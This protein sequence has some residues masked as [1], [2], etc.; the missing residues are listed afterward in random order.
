MTLANRQALPHLAPSL[1]IRRRCL[2]LLTGVLHKTVVLLRKARRISQSAV[3]RAADEVHARRF[4]T[5]AIYRLFTQLLS[6]AY[7]CLIGIV[8]GPDL[9]MNDP[10]VPLTAVFMLV[11]GVLLVMDARRYLK[12]RAQVDAQ[13]ASFSIATPSASTQPI[14]SAYCRMS[15]TGLATAIGRRASPPSMRMYTSRSGSW[16]RRW[17]VGVGSIPYK[18]CF[19]A[20][21]PQILNDL[22]GTFRYLPLYPDPLVQVER[23]HLQLCVLLPRRASHTTHRLVD[24][25]VE[26]LE[27][28]AGRP[29]ARPRMHLCFPRLANRLFFDGS[30]DNALWL[31][32]IGR[33]SHVRRLPVVLNSS[34]AL[35]LA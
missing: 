19:L 10:Y 31:L 24:C 30:D 29:V 15:P 23:C 1:L 22:A 16:W 32:A 3:S 25:I 7:M 21:S 34:R 27:P 13:I 4:P 18:W 11:G 35:F 33:R 9:E 8:R 26:G 28:T 5:T 6:F 20:A 2:S 14:V 17:W 12:E